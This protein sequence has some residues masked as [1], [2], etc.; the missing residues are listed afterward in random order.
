MARGGSKSTNNNTNNSTSSNEDLNYSFTAWSPLQTVKDIS[1]ELGLTSISNDVLKTLAMDVEYRILEVIENANKLKKFSKRSK[2]THDDIQKSMELLNLEPLFGYGHYNNKS[3]QAVGSEILSKFK[4]MDTSSDNKN[5]NVSEEYNN[6]FYIDE[7]EVDF[8]KLIN[9]P[10]P[11][12]PRITTFTSHWL[13]VEGV[14]PNIAQNPNIHEDIRLKYSP[15]VRG[16]I[17]T[18]INENTLVL[19]NE[20][21][22]NDDDPNNDNND[23]DLEKENSGENNLDA[24]TTS[25]NNSINSN[26][27]IDGKDVEIKLRVKHVISKE[28]QIYFE[29]ITKSLLEPSEEYNDIQRESIKQAALQSLSSDKGIHQLLPYFIAFINEQITYNLHDLEKLT[30]LLEMVFSILVNKDFSLEPYYNSLIPC[31][32][33]L[34]LAKNI[35]KLE[36]KSTDNDED[37]VPQQDALLDKSLAIRNFSSQVLEHILSNKDLNKSNIIEKTIKPKIIRTILKTFLDKNRSMGT[38]YGCFKILIIMGTNNTEIIRW[39]LGNLFNWCEVVLPVSDNK[40]DMDVEENGKPQRFTE[41][42]KQILLDVILDFLEVLNKD[43]PGLITE[44]A[45]KE[46]S[47]EEK[48]KL[49]KV[50]GGS[51][52]NTIESIEIERKRKIYESIFLGII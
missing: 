39:F 26:V 11:E 20:N 32:L 8:D 4:K 13:A 6:R 31:I 27:K 37:A 48:T 43:L 14:Q 36:E 19:S 30:T 28:L 46:L 29:K 49:K 16:S 9:E 42:E 1:D 51:V 15:L 18:S 50:V 41:K 7:E 25:Q 10:L 22:Q 23:V 35:G 44:N 40:D 17:V 21:D 38:Y 45:N 52:F 12:A 5:S 2:L 24:K 34:L 33:T 47:P 3:S